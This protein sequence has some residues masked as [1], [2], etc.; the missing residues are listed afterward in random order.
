MR[1]S[2]FFTENI[3]IESPEFKRW[4]GASKVVDRRGKPLRLYHGTSARFDQFFPWSHFGT[5][6]AANDR[7]ADLDQDDA[8]VIPVYLRIEHPLR[9]SDAEASDE[10]TLLN[11]MVRGKYG[12]VDLNKARRQGVRRVLMDLGYDGLVYRN[13]ME[14]R[15]RN[16][17]VIFN[18]KQVRL[19]LSEAI[20]I[21][22]KAQRF[23]LPTEII[24]YYDDPHRRTDDVGDKGWT[25]NRLVADMQARG[26]RKPIE[27]GRSRVD[28]KYDNDQNVYAIN[29]N[30]RLAA[31]KKLGRPFVWCV[32]SASYDAVPLTREDILALGGRIT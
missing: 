15:G 9:V 31:W 10:A 32:N 27:V 18:P 20:D 25:I 23:Q 4:F 26:Q 8:H 16:S 21:T 19:A 7:L 3:D 11:A 6:K 13:R 17:W 12:D 1:Y 14:H 30:H 29:G 22:G 28:L 5:T 24:K 2:E